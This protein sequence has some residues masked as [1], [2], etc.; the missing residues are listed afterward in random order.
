MGPTE[1]EFEFSPLFRSISL[2]S[3]FMD[4]AEYRAAVGPKPLSKGPWSRALALD[5][6]DAFF[7]TTSDLRTLRHSVKVQSYGDYAAAR[8]PELRPFALLSL[9][10]CGAA[11]PPPSGQLA[12]V[13]RYLRAFIPPAL[14]LPSGPSSPSSKPVKTVGSKLRFFPKVDVPVGGGRRAA[15]CIRGSDLVDAL[16]RAASGQSLLVLTDVPLCDPAG[17]ELVPVV[18]SDDGSVTLL[19]AA[20]GGDD[21]VAAE[22][23]R[24]ACLD[25]SASFCRVMLRMAPCYYFRCLL[26]GRT[27]A[28]PATTGPAAAASAHLCPICLRKLGHAA[29]SADTGGLGRAGTTAGPGVGGGFDVVARYTALARQYAAPSGC[30]RMAGGG[31]SSSEEARWM[32]ERLFR[33]TGDDVAWETAARQAAADDEQGGL[34]GGGSV[35]EGGGPAGE[36]QRDSMGSL[37]VSRPLAGEEGKMPSQRDE[38]DRSQ[39]HQR[40][41]ETHRPRGGGGFEDQSLQRQQQ[42]QLQRQTRP[43]QDRYYRREEP[44]PSPSGWGS[45]VVMG[46]MGGGSAPPR[47]APAAAAAPAPAA[48]AAT[49]TTTTTTTTTC[50]PRGVAVFDFDKTLAVT[51]VGPIHLS[52]PVGRVFG[53]RERLDRIKGLLGRLARDRVECAV[54]SFNDAH[55]IRRALDGA[56]LG[57]CFK[58]GLVYG[59]VE[60]RKACFQRKRNGGGGS[61]GGIKSGAIIY[62]I[63]PALGLHAAERVAFVDDDAANIRD[64]RSAIPASCSIHVKSKLARMGS[65]RPDQHGMTEATCRELE[66]WAAA[67]PENRAGGGRGDGGATTEA[68]APQPSPRWAAQE[69]AAS[70]VA[71]GGPPPPEGGYW[72]NGTDGADT[73]QGAA[74]ATRYDQQPLGPMRSAATA[75]TPVDP[76][77][78]RLLKAKQRNRRQFSSSITFG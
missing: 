63:M 12:V 75:N 58:P 62:G 29:T 25:A 10:A 1:T 21:R 55:V 34:G 50:P 22:V 7:T 27:M 19:S 61:G 23:V 42:Q 39:Y 18:Q 64:V 48:V 30:W 36:G 3:F 2:P 28:T 57:D 52:D 53:G 67:L 17:R 37:P 26:N 11:P 38:W 43:T 46:G 47:A 13:E 65:G 73:H 45:E 6:G 66:G 9:P 4:K 20:G 60:A 15:S 44:S 54:L 51:E 71:A 59:M 72:S 31:S 76:A 74:V 40:P 68:R 77:K 32:E 14:V 69:G 8:R 5:P 49:T 56:G 41:P 33:I 24:D 35:S 78:L 16:T 70:T